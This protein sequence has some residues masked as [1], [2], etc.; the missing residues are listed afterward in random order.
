[1]TPGSAFRILLAALGLF[2]LGSAV[3]GRGAD[4]GRYTLTPDSAVPADALRAAIAPIFGN[5]EIG[6][7]RALLVMHDGRIIAERYA[8]GF[9]PDTKL[10]S[11]SIAK[12]VTGVLVGLLVSDGRLALDAPAPVPAWS[13]PGD[14]R[15]AIT[16]RQLLTM[17]SGLDHIESGEPVAGTD[18][19]RMLFTRGAQDMAAYAEAKPLAHAPGSMFVY[20]TPT[21]Q[22]LSD[23][24]TRSLTN[25]ADPEERRAA[26]TRFIDERLKDPLGLSSLIP[27]FDAR[28]TMIG[29]AMMHMTARDYARFGE[30]LRNRGRADGRQL[31]SE[32]WVDF[33]TTP[34][35][36]NPAYGGQLWLNRESAHGTLFPGSGPA[37]L[38][39]C[40]GHNGQYILVSPSQGLTI[41][42]LG[43]STDEERVPLRQALGRL[44]ELFPS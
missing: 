9:G 5:G 34:S 41:V 23:I 12:S 20:S 29:G 3:P 28:G 39:G 24:V 10:P 25:S 40:V 17:T 8:P 21:A 26:M 16:L 36:R 35:P 27:E 30:F 31:L 15:G 11:W 32:R 4:A 38:F 13:Q 7:T 22:I 6:K 19:A 33:M 1:M 18:T 44:V 14:P 37:S 43:V 2:G 42:R